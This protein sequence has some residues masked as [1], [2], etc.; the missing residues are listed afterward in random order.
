MTLSASAII[1]GL[2]MLRAYAPDVAV[3]ATYNQP[4]RDDG[5]GLVVFSAATGDG[6]RELHADDIRRMA[7]D[8]WEWVPGYFTPGGG[9]WR[10][11]GS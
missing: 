10:L 2:T 7:S 9:V 3:R 5:S 6:L 8:G 4:T 11:L 1:N